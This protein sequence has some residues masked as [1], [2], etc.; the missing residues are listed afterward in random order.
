[1]NDSVSPSISIVIPV[2]NSDI[3]LP[4]LVERTIGTLDS[5]AI[6][7]EIILV[8][9]GSS[10]NSW[11]VIQALAQRYQAVAG[12]KL[13]QNMGQNPATIIG[14]Q[15][16]R[17]MLAVTLDD[18]LQHMPEHIP[19][20][21]GALSSRIGIVYAGPSVPMKGK[22]YAKLIAMVKI[23]FVV[24]CRAPFLRHMQTYRLLRL[25]LYP[26]KMLH[27][28]KMITVEG[29]L[30]TIRPQAVKLLVPFQPRAIGVSTYTLSKQMMLMFNIIRYSLWEPVPIGENSAVITAMAGWL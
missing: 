8:D 13:V 7:H 9:D 24:I 30:A 15:H 3:T 23:S 1:M 18:D 21:L 20:M 11:K 25:N 17:C 26:W 22:A 16:A 12:I 29:V 6:T 14:L 28:T 5:H 19:L 4:E 2:F 10:D 27:V